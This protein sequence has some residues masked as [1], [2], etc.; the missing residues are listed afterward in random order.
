MTYDVVIIGAGIAGIAAAKRLRLAGLNVVVLEA[1]DRIGGRVWTDRSSGYPVEFGAE[2]VHG[3]E[4]STWDILKA[5]RIETIPMALIRE[6]V[7]HDGNKLDVQSLELFEKTMTGIETYSGNE[8]SISD[9]F[10]SASGEENLQDLLA[11]SIGDYEAGDSHQLSML[12][13]AKC[14]SNLDDGGNFVL[15]KGY[16]AVIQSISEGIPIELGTSV[17]SVDWS[18]E[19]TIILTSKGEFRT[20]KL[21]VTVSLGIL[22][23][24]D[25]AFTPGL[26]ESKQRAVDE[27]GMGITTKLLMTFSEQV[28]I[29]EGITNTLMTVSCWW[30]VVGSPNAVMGFTG[31]ERAQKLASMN[32]E[33]LYQVAL[34]ELTKITGMDCRKVWVS[35]KRIV[36]DQNQEFT[37]GSYSNEPLGMPDD[38]RARLASPVDNKLF[39]AGE[40]TV[41]DGNHATVHGALDSGLRAAN[42]IIDLSSTPPSS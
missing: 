22:K 19:E 6:L 14:W 7:D 24:G 42:E 5:H 20:K 1:Q 37:G 17:Q 3:S 9:Y 39:F 28:P 33:R 15:P 35:S 12:H 25:I 18:G 38:A 23:R 4:V 16:D 29:I 41:T 2:F 10:K 11:V 34:D 30:P 13:I 27:V 40:A 36:W 8:Q 26:P 21:L 31:G 32:E